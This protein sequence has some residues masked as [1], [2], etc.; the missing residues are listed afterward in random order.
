MQSIQIDYFEDVTIL[1][2]LFCGSEILSDGGAVKHCPHTLFV[3]TDDG[4]EYM[5]ERVQAML[6]DVDVD[7][8]DDD[9][10]SFAERLKKIDGLPSDAFFIESYGPPIIPQGMYIGFAP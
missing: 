8:D 1:Y 4:Y 3:A 9:D 5:A 6:P 10:E 7:F 2:C